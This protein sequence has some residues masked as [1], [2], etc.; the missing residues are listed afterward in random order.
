MDLGLLLLFNHSFPKK[1]TRQG[2]SPRHTT[3]EKFVGS[4]DEPGPGHSSPDIY[5]KKFWGALVFFLSGDF[6]SKP[7]YQTFL[8]FNLRKKFQYNTIALRIS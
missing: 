5:T 6:W 8:T 3:P 1:D 2:A 7:S 4:Q